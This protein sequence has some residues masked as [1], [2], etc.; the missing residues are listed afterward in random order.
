MNKR[1]LI[2]NYVEWI[3]TVICVVIGELIIAG[4]LVMSV[5]CNDHVIT[6]FMV[7]MLFIS[8][9][10]IRE[11]NEEYDEIKDLEEFILSQE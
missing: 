7:A 2:N 1:N 9:F 3:A 6:I 4:C 5:L 11:L 8:V 10:V